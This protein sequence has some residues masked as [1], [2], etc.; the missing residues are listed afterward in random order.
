MLYALQVVSFWCTP[1]FPKNKEALVDAPN[2]LIASISYWCKS[3]IL[4][5]VSFS[6]TMF[7]ITE[8]FTSIAK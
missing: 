6:N 1:N 2:S 5:A 7:F 4:Y 3:P 8:F